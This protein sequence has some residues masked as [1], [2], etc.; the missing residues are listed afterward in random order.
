VVAGQIPYWSPIGAEQIAGGYQVV[1]KLI[2]GDQYTLWTTDY[3]G[4][5]VSFISAMPGSSSV[6]K[7]AETTFQQDLNG[8]G[9]IGVPTIVIEAFGS[10]SLTAVGNTYH[11]YNGG[12]GPELKFQGSPV[13]AGQIPYWSPIGAEQIAGGYQVVWKLIGGDQYTL[14]TT[15]NSGNFVSFVSAM[16]GSSTVLRSAETTF[17]QDLNGDRVIGVPTTVIEAFGS[18]SLTA[19]GNNYHLYSGGVGPELKFQGSPVVVGQIPYWSPIAA[20]QISGGY[21]VVWKQIGGD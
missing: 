3:S 21:Q 11:L 2:G 4:N 17:H 10:T 7:T 16:P 18:T 1:W 20:E 19:V 8:D 5:F 14:W 15:D 12:I 13:V 9:V 6:L